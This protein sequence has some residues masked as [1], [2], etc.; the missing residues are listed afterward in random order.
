MSHFRNEFMGESEPEEMIECL[1]AAND[2]GIRAERQ[3]RARWPAPDIHLPSSK[4]DR[5]R[6]SHIAAE[7]RKIVNRAVFEAMAK[8]ILEKYEERK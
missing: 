5:E 7:R 4:E 2:A 6:L 8:V 3:A 1:K